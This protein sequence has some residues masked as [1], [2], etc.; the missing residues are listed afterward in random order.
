MRRT[1]A[2]LF[3]ALGTLAANAEGNTSAY[4]AFD[5]EKC[6]VIEPGDEYVYAGTWACDGYGGIDIIQASADDRSYAAF[7][8]NGIGI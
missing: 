2:P 3:L 8:T 5:L 6:R 7:G 4:T 1:L